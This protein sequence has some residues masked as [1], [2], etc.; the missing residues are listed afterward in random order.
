MEA[1]RI[2]T[3][4]HAGFKKLRFYSSWTP[5]E[6]LFIGGTTFKS[7]RVL[8]RSSSIRKT[9]G[10]KIRSY[11][12]RLRKW[13]ENG[14]TD[15]EDFY[16]RCV[17]DSRKYERK[18]WHIPRNPCWVQQCF[19]SVWR[20][21]PICWMTWRITG[22]DSFVL[23]RK[24]SPLILAST[25][26][27]LDGN[28]LEWCLWTPQSV[29]NQ[30][31]SLNYDAWHHSLERGEDSS[32]C[33]WKGLQ[34]NLCHLPKFWKQRFFHGWRRSL[35]N[36][37]KSANRTECRH[38]RKR[39]C[40]TSWMP[41]ELLVHRFFDHSHQISMPSTSAYE[42]TLRKRLDRYATATYGG[43]WANA[44]SGMTACSCAQAAHIE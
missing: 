18:V 1:K 35:R 42:L 16:L 28:V 39:L 24:L 40:R 8:K 15:T 29:N 19:R 32:D 23:V 33:I 9:S 2:E 14:K 37:I 12:K 21:V 36:P 6:W 34:A 4:L 17:Q 5:V 43:R 31:F 10:Y 3:F 22:I 44:S 11:P 25:I 7:F 41:N 30:V 13:Q 26:E 20:E 38:I 27:W